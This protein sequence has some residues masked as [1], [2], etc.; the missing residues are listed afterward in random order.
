MGGGGRAGE[1]ERGK[2]HFDFLLL[3]AKSLTME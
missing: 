2:R 3:Q 1:T